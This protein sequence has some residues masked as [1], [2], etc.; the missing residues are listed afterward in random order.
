MNASL[1][2]TSLLLAAALAVSACEPNA[3][4]ETA[5]PRAWLYAKD[6]PEIQRIGEEAIAAHEAREA[7]RA[8]LMRAAPSEYAVHA[9]AEREMRSA[10]STNNRMANANTALLAGETGDPASEAEATEAALSAAAPEQYA[11]YA[12]AIA[13]LAGT[14]NVSDI[15]AAHSAL[16]AV[17]RA[18]PKNFAAY[19]SASPR[20]NVQVQAIGSAYRGVRSI[21][22]YK[23][24]A[25]ALQT[26]APNLWA[27]W[28]AASEEA[29]RYK[30]FVVW[31]STEPKP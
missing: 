24:A 9:R 5:A 27:V 22:A 11:D 4:A 26:A 2:P 19:Q 1:F 17:R 10:V 8:A 13:G 28:Q 12:R 7:A 20:R 14:Q 21:H 25:H 29:E 3:E 30:G 18:A 16:V 15:V 31:K 23:K 6:A